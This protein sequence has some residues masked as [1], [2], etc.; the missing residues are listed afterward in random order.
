M[1][2]MEHYDL[3]IISYDLA[4]HLERC[5]IRPAFCT[6]EEY[7]G[8][9]KKFLRRTETARVHMDSLPAF[10]PSHT[11]GTLYL[12]HRY[13]CDVGPH[14]SSIDPA[15]NYEYLMTIHKKSLKKLTQTE[16]RFTLEE[17][18]AG[19]TMIDRHLIGHESKM[20]FDREERWL[21]NAVR[22][23][24]HYISKN[25][26]YGTTEIFYSFLPEDYDRKLI[27]ILSHVFIGESYVR[28]NMTFEFSKHF[29]L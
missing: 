27:T 4:K 21:A 9:R 25:K 10:N 20:F 29:L 11:L 18:S 2:T 14:H 1:E 19:T 16:P 5:F 17:A 23:D 8:I 15:N 7:R 24:A 13:I 12:R 22:Y 3:D 26:M 6:A 28:H